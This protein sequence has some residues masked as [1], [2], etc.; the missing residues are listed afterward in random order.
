MHAPIAS[1][2]DYSQTQ[3]IKGAL[4]FLKED[5]IYENRMKFHQ[6]REQL[7]QDLRSGKI[8]GKEYTEKWD[9]MKKDRPLFLQYGEIREP[10][11]PGGLYEHR[12]LEIKNEIDTDEY[13]RK[14]QKLEKDYADKKGDFAKL[15][16][17][18]QSIKGQYK[19]LYEFSKMTK[20]MCFGLSSLWSYCI[21]NNGEDNINWFFKYYNMGIDFAS[22]GDFSIEKINPEDMKEFRRFLGLVIHF[23]QLMEDF[24][25]DKASL[26]EEVIV[27]K[28]TGE[29]VIRAFVP[30]LLQEFTEI[31]IDLKMGD[32]GLKQDEYLEKETERLAALLDKALHK[33][34]AVNLRMRVK[35]PVILSRSHE[36]AIYQD[37][38][39]KIYFYDPNI[40]EKFSWQAPGIKVADYKEA[41]KVLLDRAYHN[42]PD[43]IGKKNAFIFNMRPTC[44]KEIQRIPAKKQEITE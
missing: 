13:Y 39:K 41:A 7:F 28:G 43:A 6:R 25:D 29:T 14:M 17:P 37:K 21:Q 20:G 26:M 34:K 16:E 40:N 38:D 2:E 5:M 22:A 18:D 33:G 3:F 11:D 24:D 42:Y 1:A 15:Y 35:D 23:Q 30:L 4:R 10:S 44:F 31:Q 36:T 27:D 9:A 32:H 19:A 8:S 12:K